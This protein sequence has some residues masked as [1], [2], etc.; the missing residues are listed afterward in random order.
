VIVAVFWL[1]ASAAWANG[2]L[3]LK[4]TA[5]PAYWI[6][7]NTQLVI[8]QNLS[9]PLK[10]CMYLNDVTQFRTILTPIVTV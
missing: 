7:R 1:S 5:D 4:Q 8:G 9:K 10:G 3:N 2:I 6:F